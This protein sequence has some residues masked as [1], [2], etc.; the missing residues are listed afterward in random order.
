MKA[1]TLTAE[2]LE[3]S[4]RRGSPG[5]RVARTMDRLLSELREGTITPRAALQKLAL[6]SI[7]AGRDL[8]IETAEEAKR[9]RI[10][11]AEPPQER[12]AEYLDLVLSYTDVPDHKQDALSKALEARLIADDRRPL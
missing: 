7:R 1:D 2:R 8:E 10:V 5:E 3:N 4:T 12:A 11:K 9:L 6:V